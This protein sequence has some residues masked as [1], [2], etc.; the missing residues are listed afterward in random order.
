M[1]TAL[2]YEARGIEPELNLFRSGGDRR[3][4]LSRPFFFL[5]SPFS[6]SLS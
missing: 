4:G 3:G 6:N 1:P 2:H 5:E